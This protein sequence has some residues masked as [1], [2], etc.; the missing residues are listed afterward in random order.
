MTGK[1]K[2]VYRCSECGG[3]SPKWL[4]R[5]PD[6]GAWNTLHEEREERELKCVSN[7]LA[8]LSLEK[9]KPLPLCEIPLD[10]SN[11]ISTDIG[12]LDRVLGGGLVAGGV[13]LLGGDPG[14]G[15]STLMLQTAQK[16]ADKGLVVLYITGEESAVQTRMR[17]HRLGKSAKS[18]FV[19]AETSLS[20]AVE[21]ISN[22][23][24]VMVVVDSIQ[25]MYLDGLESSPGSI[26]QVREV[27]SVLM[28]LAKK[29]GVTVFIVGHMTKSGAIAGPRVIEHLVDTVLY[30]EGEGSHTYR[31]LRAVKN[32]FGSTNEIGVFEMCGEGLKE[33]A[34]PSEL[35]LSERASSST[36]TAVTACLEG[37]RPILVEV[38]ALVSPTN[39]GMPQRAA[40]G[41]DR[42]R[43][44]LIIAVLERKVGMMFGTNDVFVNVAGGL[45]I[46]EPA[47]DLALAM[48]IVSS[49]K[50][51]ALDADTIFFGEIGLAGEIRAVA[52]PEMR[53]LEGAKLGFKNCLMPESNYKRLNVPKGIRVR[54][55]KSIAHALEII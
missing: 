40:Q 13:V 18:L 48:A 49:Y 27:S 5:C 17:A 12:E 15:K 32:R 3:I 9:A 2:T 26:A 47:A 11:R 1:T 44:A 21:A 7:S 53:L 25:T 16:L 42:G 55:V 6:C 50:D 34:N 43:L 19:M 38:Q 35:F 41:I 52:Q 29:T 10:T 36:G 54:P 20:S 45:K 46:A 37:S 8:G 51:M 24:P 28:R 31:I 14:I 30:F 23:S 33:V 39:Y 22:L 4:G